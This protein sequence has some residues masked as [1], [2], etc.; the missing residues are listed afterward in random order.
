MAHEMAHEMGHT[1]EQVARE[2]DPE[3]LN[4]WEKQITLFV[5]ERTVKTEKSMPPPAKPASKTFRLE[6]PRGAI[7]YGSSPSYQVRRS[8]SVA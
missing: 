2:S 4:T 1:L 3:I 8:C 6:E 7:R 5:M